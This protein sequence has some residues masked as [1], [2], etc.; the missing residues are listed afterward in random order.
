MSL[1]TNLEFVRINDD[2]STGFSIILD[3]EPLP[4]WYIFNRY[5]N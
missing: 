3:L 1:A 5:L 2:Y 4:L